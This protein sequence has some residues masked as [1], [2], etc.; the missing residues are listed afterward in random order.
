[1]KTRKW[2]EIRKG[3]IIILDNDTEF[4]GFDGKQILCCGK[5]YITGFWANACGLSKAQGK[6]V[7]YLI[8]AIELQNFRGVV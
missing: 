3:S 7:D 6:E 4:N 5:Y 8:P 2:D 1:M